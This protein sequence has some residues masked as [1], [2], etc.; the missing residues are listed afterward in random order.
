MHQHLG[1][2]VTAVAFAAHNQMKSGQQKAQ[3]FPTACLS[4]SNQIIAIERNGPGLGA[5][6]GFVFAAQRDGAR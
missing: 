4:N 3:R 5:V 2:T 1:P 6:V